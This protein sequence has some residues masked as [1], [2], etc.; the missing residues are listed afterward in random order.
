MA[1]AL[2]AIAGVLSIPFSAA[3]VASTAK[4][5]LRDEGTYGQTTFVIPN[6]GPIHPAE[7]PTT[8]PELHFG[9]QWR[10][11]HFRLVV[12][13]WSPQAQSLYAVFDVE[14]EFQ[15]AEP[16]MDWSCR[17]DGRKLFWTVDLRTDDS[18]WTK[19]E[20]GTFDVFVPGCGRPAIIFRHVGTTRAQARRAVLKHL[21]GFYVSRL[22]CVSSGRSARCNVTFNNTFSQCEATYRV[23]RIY[24]GSFTYSAVTAVRK[25]CT[26]F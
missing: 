12:R 19:R 1:G 26:S 25:H 21:A 15:E 9:T 13:A 16:V 14:G 23:N 3:A 11:C 6:G 17:I 8:Q 20:T 2:L 10:P 22:R 24:N 18:T 7:C 5:E 4:T